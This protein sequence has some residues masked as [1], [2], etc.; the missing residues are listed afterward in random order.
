MDLKKIHL[1]ELADPN[2]QLPPKPI[3]EWYN[4]RPVLGNAN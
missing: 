3:S 4:L 2:P 1:M